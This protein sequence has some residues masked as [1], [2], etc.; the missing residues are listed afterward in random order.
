M[1]SWLG[2][3]RVSIRGRTFGLFFVRYSGRIG[4]IYIFLALRLDF[5]CMLIK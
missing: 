4:N 3:D 1:K 5:L 2:V